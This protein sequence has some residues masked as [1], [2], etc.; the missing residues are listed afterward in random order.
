MS[1]ENFCQGFNAHISKDT[2]VLVLGSMPSVASLQAGQYYAHPR[3]RF[4]PLI[5]LLLENKEAPQDYNERLAMLARHGVGLWD[6][7]HTCERSGSLDADIKNEEPN[8]FVKVLESYPQIRT[9]CC[10]G[11]KAWQ[12]FKKH[13]KELLKRDGLRC[14]PMPSTSPAN[15][16][17]TLAEL[18]EVWREGI[19]E[20]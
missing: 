2:R 18:A 20:L 10:N 3:N 19:K 12:V 8:D 6:A 14:L 13:N 17:M 16:R 11:G 7:L 15:A 1:G 9:I 4:W 5:S